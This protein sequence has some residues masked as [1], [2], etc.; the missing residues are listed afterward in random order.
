M[1]ALIGKKDEPAAICEQ[2]AALGVSCTDC[3][4]GLPY[5][6]FLSAVDVDGTRVPGLQITPKN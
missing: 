2:A 5:C 6:M 3:P 4:D 1:G